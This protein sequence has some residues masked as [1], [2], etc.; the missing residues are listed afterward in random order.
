MAIA[1]REVAPLAHASQ[2]VASPLLSRAAYSLPGHNPLFLSFEGCKSGNVYRI[3]L[4]Y[5]SD[6]NRITCFT[7]VRR[8]WWKNLRGGV[9]A[10]VDIEGQCWQGIAEA[11]EGHQETIAR[12]LY[13]FLLRL[14]ENAQY[15]NVRLDIVG[16]PYHTDVIS[17]A[18]SSVLIRIE[19][20][21]IDSSN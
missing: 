19:L 16:R 3:P 7:S 1:Q 6:K 9:P 20:G 14:P 13:K 10:T 17:S 5:M 15:M 12:E 11:T 4:R 8:M 2:V 21:R 18:L